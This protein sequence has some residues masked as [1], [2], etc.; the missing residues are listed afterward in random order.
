MYT[1]AYSSR[2]ALLAYIEF[3]PQHLD[4]GYIKVHFFADF[5]IL[6]FLASAMRAVNRNVI[7]L[8]AATM[9]FI[10]RAEAHPGSQPFSPQNLYGLGAHLELAADAY[11][12]NQW[13]ELV[14]TPLCALV[15]NT[16]L[17]SGR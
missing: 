9:M 17:T 8:L 1:D 16:L 3:T 11:V 6:L 15:R 7:L 5:L 2:C 14:S 12:H 13:P 10:V 4:T